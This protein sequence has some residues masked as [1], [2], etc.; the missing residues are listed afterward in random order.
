MIFQ[1]ATAGD[2][3][4]L[5][6]N[7]VQ[8]TA[9]DE[10]VNVAFHTIKFEMDDNS[11]D[12]ETYFSVEADGTITLKKDLNDFPYPDPDD[13]TIEVNFDTTGITKLFF[14]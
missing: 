10:D 5:N 2:L 6:N 8:I 3:L 13:N 7:T 9:T 11:N 1:N 12:V 14:N 4:D